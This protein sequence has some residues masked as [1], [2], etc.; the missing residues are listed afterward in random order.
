MDDHAVKNLSPEAPDERECMQ[1]DQASRLTLR[2][3]AFILACNAVNAGM[4]GK[5]WNPPVEVAFILS[6]LV[7]ARTGPKAYILWHE[8]DPRDIPGEL[9]LVPSATEN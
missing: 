5:S 6:Y 4:N 7:I 3:L 1:R 9:E 2:F 8:P